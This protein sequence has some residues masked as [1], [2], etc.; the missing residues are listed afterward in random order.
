ME[1]CENTK[2]QDVIPNVLNDRLSVI[3]SNGFGVLSEHLHKV[4]VMVCD[5]VGQLCNC[6]SENS[7]HM[8]I[9]KACIGLS[10]TCK[11]NRDLLRPTIMRWAASFHN[12][13]PRTWVCRGCSNR[14][15]SDDS[16]LML[17]SPR[18]E[19]ID[20]SCL[21]SR[22]IYSSSVETLMYSYYDYGSFYGS[23]ED[24]SVDSSWE[25]YLDRMFQIGKVMVIDVSKVTL[26]S[27]VQCVPTPSETDMVIS[28]WTGMPIKTVYV[29]IPAT[30][31]H[32]FDPDH[33]SL[34]QCY[35][36]VMDAGSSDSIELANGLFEPSP[37]SLLAG[38]AVLQK[39]M[40]LVCGVLPSLPRRGKV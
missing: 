11:S 25:E 14:S 27:Q 15:G 36:E 12:H 29:Y 9:V 10:R 5:G 22:G 2:L 23:A 31:S 40:V 17:S 3:A 1:L 39:N 18:F 35:Q 30:L 38:V 28:D 37:C 32:H 4:Q 24:E 33:E 20:F 26:K 6:C 7:F 13:R 21:S 8:T 19:S 16:V 34:V